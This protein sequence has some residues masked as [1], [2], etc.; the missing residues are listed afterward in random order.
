[1][2]VAQLPRLV[3]A[4]YQDFAVHSIMPD[5]HAAEQVAADVTAAALTPSATSPDV[6]LFVGRCLRS[7]G[8]C[9]EAAAWYA[10]VLRADQA[11]EAD[12][13]RIWLDECCVQFCGQRLRAY[14]EAQGEVPGLACLF[15]HMWTVVSRAPSRCR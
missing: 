9:Q 10:S 5:A 15:E 12:E 3:A 13:T 6:C 11:A 8:R 7:V 14:L 4:A 1:M 2:Q